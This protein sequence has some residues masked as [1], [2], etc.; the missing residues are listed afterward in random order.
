MGLITGLLAGLNPYVMYI[1]IAIAVAVVG[2]AMYITHQYDQNAYEAEK[3]KAIKK[4]HVLLEA[5][6]VQ[7][8]ARIAQL[9]EI[10]STTVAKNA[11]TVAKMKTDRAKFEKERTNVLQKTGDIKLS[12]G[13][14]RLWNESIDRVN[15]SVPPG[16]TVASGTPEANN[17]TTDSGLSSA[18][19]NHDEITQ[20]CGEW[21]ARLDSIKAWDANTFP[22]H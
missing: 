3:G 11:A 10:N 14:W 12:V 7:Y 8:Q 17:T 21:K 6:I 19:G 13:F 15:G 5:S 4:A 9:E 20:L 1:K 22:A 2:G 16:A 18:L